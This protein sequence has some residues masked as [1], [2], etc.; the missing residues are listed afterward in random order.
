[1]EGE[2]TFKDDHFGTVHG[3]SLG[4]SFV[5]DKVVDG[6]FP[7][8][9]TAFGFLL[10]FQGLGKLLQKPL[11]CVNKPSPSIRNILKG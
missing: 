3:D 10:T 1:M 5:S 6:F 4:L 8:I 11:F 9:F 7:Q 2:D